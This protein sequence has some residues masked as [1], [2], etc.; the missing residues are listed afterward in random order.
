[1]SSP[2]MTGTA[3]GSEEAQADNPAIIIIIVGALRL[4]QSY[5]KESVSKIFQDLLLW[6]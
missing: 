3:E 1:M 5:S 6:E 4:C 2:R